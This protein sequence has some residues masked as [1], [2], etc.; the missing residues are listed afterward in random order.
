[1]NAEK[2]V[3]FERS[4][5]AVP[6]ELCTARLLLRT[7]TVAQMQAVADAEPDP[8]MHAAYLEMV[9]AMRRIPGREQW[10]CDWEIIRRD[11]GECVGGIGFKGVPDERGQVEVGYGVDEPHRRRGFATEAA[12]ALCRWALEQ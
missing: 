8:E 2:T 4:D 9:D 7:R 5:A 10:A 1:M 11:T 12:A 3:D 6:I